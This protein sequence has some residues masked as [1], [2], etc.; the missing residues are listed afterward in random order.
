MS[1]VPPQVDA[2]SQQVVVLHASTPLTAGLWHLPPP[3]L[4]P[5]RPAARPPDGRCSAA[6][7]FSRAKGLLSCCSSKA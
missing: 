5:L 4:E 7:R 2:A 6:E 1:H 3:P